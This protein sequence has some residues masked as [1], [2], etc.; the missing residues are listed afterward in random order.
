ML[1]CI[2]STDTGGKKKKKGQFTRLLVGI[3]E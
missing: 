2:M 1:S 3:A